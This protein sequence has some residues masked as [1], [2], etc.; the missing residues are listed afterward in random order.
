[1]TLF[2]FTLKAVNRIPFLKRASQ[3]LCRYAVL[4]DLTRGWLNKLYNSLNEKERVI[5]HYMFAR[6]FRNGKARPLN[7]EW[8]IKFNNAKIKMPLRT[9]TLWLDWDLAVSI[10]G[11]DLEIKYFY[12]KFINLKRPKYFLDI[13]ANY[14]THSLLFLSQGVKSITFE[15]NPECMPVFQ[16]LLTANHLQGQLEHYALGESNSSAELVFPKNDTWNGSL[17]KGYQHDMETSADLT[18]IKVE[19]VSLDNWVERH[20]IIPNIIKIDT[21]GFELNVLRGGRRTITESKAAIVFETNNPQ[22]RN[23]LFNEFNLLGYDIYELKGALNGGRRF[24]KENFIN[25]QQTNFLALS[26]GEGI[27]EYN[28]IISSQKDKYVGL[29]RDAS[30]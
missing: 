1:M 27:Q 2:E 30:V 19:I 15:P 5:F 18:R 12:E 11:H 20:K 7:V 8:T 21:E 28:E 4:H 13:G 3:S 24:S 6:I 29:G 25:S 23:D 10:M 9:E 26:I 16:S 17:D 14:G 22:E